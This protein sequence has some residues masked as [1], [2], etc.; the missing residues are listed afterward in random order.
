MKQHYLA[1]DQSFLAVE[2]EQLLDEGKDISAV[3]AEFDALVRRAADLDAD[4]GLQVPRR[5][6]FSTP[7]PNCPCAPTTP[8]TSRPAWR[9]STG[10]PDRYAAM[11]HNRSGRSDTL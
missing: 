8:M 9:A 7:A 11:V 3:A 2:R 4:S 5:G 10:P 6:D 1:I